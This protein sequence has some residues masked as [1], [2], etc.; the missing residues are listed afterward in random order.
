MPRARKGAARR[1]AKVR[2]FKLAKGKRGSRSRCWRK[3]KGAVIRAG[4]YATRHRRTVKQEYRALWITRLNAAVRTRGV[5]YSQFIQGLKLAN[6]TLNRKMLSEVA[7]AD[8][9]AFDKVL[10]Q[11]NASLKKLEKTAA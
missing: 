11:V 7:I 9:Q 2:W 6:I 3:V 8:P 4:I 5:S 10:E 1:Q